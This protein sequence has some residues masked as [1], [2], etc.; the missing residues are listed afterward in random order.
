MTYFPQLDGIR[1]VAALA[2]VMGHVSASIISVR[3]GIFFNTIVRFCA[4]IFIMLSGFGHAS[5]YMSGKRGVKLF[6][7]RFFRIFPAYL[8]WSI[9][10]IA[11]DFA[12]GAPHENI[13]KDILCGT[14]YVHLYYVFVLLQF[15]VLC[16]PICGAV[17]KWPRL[18]L[19]VSVILSLTVQMITCLDL[20]GRIK[21]P[22][23]PVTLVC[24]F[25]TWLVFYVYG[26][27]MR[28]HRNPEDKG[29][30]F[31]AGVLWAGAFSI[32]I[33][34]ANKFPGLLRPDSTLYTIATWEFLWCIFSRLKTPKP[35]K[36]VSNL[37][38][39]V[40]LSHP[41]ILRLWY[42][43]ASRQNPVIYLNL[44]NHYMLVMAGGL[45]VTFILGCIPHGALF[46]GALPSALAKKLRQN[47][48]AAA[49]KKPNWTS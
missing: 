2:V 11:L 31:P 1:A 42:E 35:F 45:L 5:A 28:Y 29:E 8:A 47:K 13:L 46:G 6:K 12:F 38:F 3:H 40:Y 10:Y 19:F 32:M 49:V 30:F 24:L 7:K 21:L 22:N 25:P 37:S 39:G 15:L 34:T 20:V 14:S 48:T 18:S 23:M 17:E 16:D 44:F 27:Y 4:P 33:L 36:E 41:L 9:A 26:V 43:W